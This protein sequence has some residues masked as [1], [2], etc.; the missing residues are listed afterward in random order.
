MF[1]SHFDSPSS[2]QLNLVPA[3]RTAK[4]Y[5]WPCWSRNQPEAC[6]SLLF[7]RKGH[8]GV[9]G[10]CPVNIY[11]AFQGPP[12]TRVRWRPPGKSPGLY[13]ERGLMSPGRLANCAT[14]SDIPLSAH[15]Q[16]CW[17]YRP[18]PPG[19]EWTTFRWIHNEFRQDDVHPLIRFNDFYHLFARHHRK[20]CRAQRRRRFI[21]G[22]GADLLPCCR[23]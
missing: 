21:A 14:A 3:R 19:E 20:T 18:Q 16:R 23:C 22:Y 10:S 6:G 12:T 7:S 8:G 5:G 17:T 15:E 4:T 2:G 9:K 1:G 13:R 11:T